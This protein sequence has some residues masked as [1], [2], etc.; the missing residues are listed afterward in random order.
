[1]MHDLSEANFCA[2]LTLSTS[3]YN[4]QNR[5]SILSMNVIKE[6]IAFILC[7]SLQL[8][9]LYK[10]IFMRHSFRYVNNNG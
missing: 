2:I 1:M 3:C 4:E 5:R 10:K 8:L 7:S 6:R 9:I